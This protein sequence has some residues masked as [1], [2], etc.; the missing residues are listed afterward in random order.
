MSAIAQIIQAISA[1]ISL[2][3]FWVLFGLA[4]V[5]FIF[6]SYV[7]SLDAPTDKSSD[8]Y[9]HWFKWSN[10]FCFRV[11]RAAIAFHIPINGETDDKAD[12]A[13]AGQ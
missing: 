4:I 9:R 6:A 11:K 8:R 2:P 5:Y 7:D 12:A 1:L 13:G 10:R 3:A